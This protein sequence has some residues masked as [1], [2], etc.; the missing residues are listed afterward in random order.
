VDSAEVMCACTVHVESGS[1][2]RYHESRAK[3]AERLDLEVPA[4]WASPSSRRLWGWRRSAF[5]AL[6]E[7]KP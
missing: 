5:L 1:E 4:G 6:L 7:T 2:S 3:A